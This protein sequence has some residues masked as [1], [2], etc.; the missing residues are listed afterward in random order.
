MQNSLYQSVAQQGKA[1]SEKYLE[2]D[3]PGVIFKEM[4]KAH[5]LARLTDL[6][7]T[8]ADGLA[9][10]N[11]RRI[12]AVFSEPDQPNDSGRPEVQGEFAVLHAC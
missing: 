9:F 12:I 2:A 10:E 1:K 8:N 11:R 5:M 7:N 3:R 6:R 4:H